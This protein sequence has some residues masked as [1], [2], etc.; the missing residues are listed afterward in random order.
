MA[1]MDWLLRRSREVA[2]ELD[3]LPD[4]ER[5]LLRAQLIELGSPR[6]RAELASTADDQPAPV[7]TKNA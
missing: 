7:S 6:N 4:W 2:R 5:A 3:A 1:D